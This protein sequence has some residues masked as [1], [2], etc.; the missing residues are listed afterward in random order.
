MKAYKVWD[1]GSVEPYSTVIFAESVREAKK[2]ARSME[3]CEDADYVNI[4][5]QRF[6]AMDE[7]YRGHVEADWFDM[8]DRKALVSLGW[9]CLET[10]DECDACPV[11]DICGHWEGEDE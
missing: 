5:V 2:I 1:N 8:E 9:M 6:P 11:K 3:V 10:S 4:R 7:H